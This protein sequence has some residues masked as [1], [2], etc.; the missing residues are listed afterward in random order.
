MW[1]SSNDEG[2]RRVAET[3]TLFREQ[4]NPEQFAIPITSSESRK[5]IPIDLNDDIIAGNTIF[6]LAGANLVA[7]GKK[8][9]DPGACVSP[10]GCG[11]E[12]HKSN[13]L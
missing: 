9:G 13:H 6:M 8:S 11:A 2:A 3:P 4:R 1:A 12:P 10:A 5:Y 7:V